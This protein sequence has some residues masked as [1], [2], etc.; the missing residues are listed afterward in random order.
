MQVENTSGAEVK[1]EIDACGLQCPGPVM[2][3]KEGLDGVARSTFI[4][5]SEVPQ[6]LADCRRSAGGRMAPAHGLF[7]EEVDY[8][9]ETMDPAWRDPSPPH[10]IS[11]IRRRPG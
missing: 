9:D 11:E 5:F 6:I 1:V 3:L 10:L 8:P 2:K 4:E 7:L